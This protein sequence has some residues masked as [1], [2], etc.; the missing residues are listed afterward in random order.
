VDHLLYG[1]VFFGAVMLILFWIG[2]R[3]RDDVGTA[4]ST[5]AGRVARHA[6]LGPSLVAGALLTSVAVTAAPLYAEFLASREPS[7]SRASTTLEPINGWTVVSA[8]PAVFRPRFLGARWTL[9]QVFEKNGRRVG[10]FI[11]YYANQHDG[12]ELI[13][14]VNSITDARD[15]SWRQVTRNRVRESGL[16]FDVIQTRLR[17]SFSGLAVW[18]WYWAG[19]RWT[20]RPEVVKVFQALDKLL[21]RGDDA[22]VVVLYT[23]S[24]SESRGVEKGLREFSQDMAPAMAAALERIRR[25]N[26]SREAVAVRV[27]R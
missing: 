21:G 2:S 20:S 9:E 11:A 14:N 18:H 22:A 1:W 10:L 7:V 27:D 8:G 15:R 24:D 4:A 19:D 6:N 25:V 23:R 13:S 26:L 5:P 12:A 17:S 3:W 16:N